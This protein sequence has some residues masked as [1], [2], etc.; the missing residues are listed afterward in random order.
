[1]LLRSWVPPLYVPVALGALYL[2]AKL[3]FDWSAYQKRTA[4]IEKRAQEHGTHRAYAEHGGEVDSDEDDYSDILEFEAVFFEWRKLVPPDELVKLTQGAIRRREPPSRWR[5][6]LVE[7]AKSARDEGDYERA[8]D[9]IK[10]A[11]EEATCFPAGES[12]QMVL[13]LARQAEGWL[14]CSLDLLDIARGHLLTSM[15]EWSAASDESNPI[16]Y[17]LQLNLARVCCE[18]DRPGSDPPFSLCSSSSNP[19]ADVATPALRLCGAACVESVQTG[20]RDPHAEAQAVRRSL[21]ALP[22]VPAPRTGALSQQPARAI[23]SV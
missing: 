15:Q 3:Y 18:D 7:A 12:K 22:R 11:L 20:A 16:M 4:E 14:H 13:A 10:E 19:G 6:L 8:R 9:L 23:C 21:P 2:S 5:E 1:M 17:E